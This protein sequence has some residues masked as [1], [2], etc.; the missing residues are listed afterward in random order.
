MFLFSFW[1]FSYGIAAI[2]PFSHRLAFDNLTSEIQHLRCKVNFEALVFVPHIRMLAESIINQ[3]RSP[4]S[5]NGGSNASYL[6][7]TRDSKQRA[8]K[9]VVL[10]LRFDKVRTFPYV[11]L[12]THP[13]N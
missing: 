8:G 12:R 13:I 2:A 1:I 3:L 9:Y 6:Q 11:N 4:P 10:H 5:N 7:E